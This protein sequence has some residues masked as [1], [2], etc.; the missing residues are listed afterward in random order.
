MLNRSQIFPE[1]QLPDTGQLVEHGRE[2][3]KI[4]KVTPGPFLKENAVVSE[5]AFKRREA[6]AGRIMQHAQIGYRDLEKSRRAWGE[7]YETCDKAGVRVARYGITLDWTMGLP[8]GPR[9]SAVKGTGMLLDGPEDFVRLTATAPVAPHFGDFIMGFPSAVENTCAALAAGAT[10]IGNLGQYFTFRPPNWNDDV[11]TTRATVTAIALLAAQDQE[12]LVHS[13]LDDGFA[14][15]FTDL[16]SVLGLVLIEK[17]V[18]EGLLGAS[19]SH[20]WGH[21][22]SDPKRRLAF[23]LALSAANTTPGTM[24]YGNTV[25]YRGGLAEN[26]A[27]LASYLLVDVVGQTVRPSGHA[28]NPVPVTENSRIPEIDEVIDA[29]L[30]AGRLAQHAGPSW[31]GLVD[32]DGAREIADE[33]QVLAERF[34]DNVL[35][36][37]EQAA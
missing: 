13:N 30:F 22:F 16:S 36:G 10:S 37:L 6:A 19:V 21:H 15:L 3:A 26:F 35:T 9:A 28:I 24:V 23:H 1:Q 25:S 7:I 20:C 32:V 8:P 31:S 18:I 17:Q 11:A 27:S 14:G 34:R 2:L 4:H 29:Q 12:V 33:L 5:A